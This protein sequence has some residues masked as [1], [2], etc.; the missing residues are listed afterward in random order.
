MNR[1]QILPVSLLGLGLAGTAA[2]LVQQ[3][4]QQRR[5]NQQT[6]AIV[7]DLAETKRITTAVGHRLDALTAMNNNLRRPEI[8]T[9]E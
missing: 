6:R 5:I 2:G 3:T 4:H 7:L 1:R 9:Y 8:S